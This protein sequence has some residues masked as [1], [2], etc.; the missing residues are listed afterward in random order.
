[1]NKNSKWLGIVLVPILFI[2]LILA[3]SVFAKEPKEKEKEDSGYE[4]SGQ[5]IMSS[6]ETYKQRGYIKAMEFPQAVQNLVASGLLTTQELPED[7]DYEEDEEE[8]SL[9]KTN[10][11]LLLESQAFLNRQ[12]E[13][14]ISLAQEE[15]DYGMEFSYDGDKKAFAEEVYDIVAKIEQYGFTGFTEQVRQVEKEY[16]K[17]QEEI[18]D[19]E[20]L[21]TN[22]LIYNQ[23]IGFRFCFMSGEK[24]HVQ[25]ILNINTLYIPEQYKTVIQNV[26]QSGKYMLRASSV[27]A[28][29][30]VL[31]F[32]TANAV[33]SQWGDEVREVRNKEDSQRSFGD[34]TISFIFENGQVTD[35]YVTTNESKLQLTEADKK[36]IQTVAPGLK[37]SLP[38][39]ENYTNNGNNLYIAK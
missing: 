1:M 31:T 6:D 14:V 38:K 25:L 2:I 9:Y 23:G 37:M 32:G 39:R 29:K 5:N 20:M 15:E 35:Y 21:D 28:K 22:Y 30:D 18:E 4:E 34:T 33:M 19:W 3:I 8:S 10:Y 24:V 17:F 12:T 27:D 13:S 7:E 26:I 11:E 36:L 16:K